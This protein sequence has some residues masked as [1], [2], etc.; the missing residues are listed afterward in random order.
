MWDPEAPWRPRE[1][2]ESLRPP[3]LTPR[4]FPPPGAGSVSFLSCAHLIQSVE[5]FLRSQEGGLCLGQVHFT[6]LLFLCDILEGSH[7][8]RINCGGAACK[9]VCVCTGSPGQQRGSMDR[10]EEGGLP[11]DAH[12]QRRVSRGA[13]PMAAAP[14]CSPSC[15]RGPRPPPGT[16]LSPPCPSAPLPLPPN[17]QVG[18]SCA[19][20]TDL[21]LWDGNWSF[22]G[23][24]LPGL[25]GEPGAMWTPCCWL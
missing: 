14:L 3:V 8:G 20:A 17:T 25:E 5:S 6:S 23:P 19:G 7:T 1:A 22:Y 10:R 18:K 2:A 4:L 16:H 15:L 13:S 9:C 21:G 24:Q 11:P 12:A